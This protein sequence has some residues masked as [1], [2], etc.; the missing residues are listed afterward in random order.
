M[1]KECSQERPKQGLYGRCSEVFLPD[2]YREL[3]LEAR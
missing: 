2:E 3:G 1:I